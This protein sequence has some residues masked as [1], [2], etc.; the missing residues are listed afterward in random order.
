MEPLRV[1]CLCAQW[2]GV[3]RDWRAGFEALAAQLP[4]ARLLWV[5][6]EDAA[7]LLDGYEPEN[8][9]V[10]AVQRGPWLLYCAAV[11]QQP[12]VW[13]RLIDAL[14]G[15]DAD[16]VQLHAARLAGQGGKWPDLRAFEEGPR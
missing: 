6:V 3:C 11:P 2:C 1:A 16:S 7:D 13:L 14:A 12:A 8:F 4:A 5:D 15:L 9:P 10:L